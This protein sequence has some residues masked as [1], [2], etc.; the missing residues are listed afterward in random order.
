MSGLLVA[1]GLA[2]AAANVAGRVARDLEASLPIDPVMAELAQRMDDFEDGEYR[3]SAPTV[4][5]LYIH[6]FFSLLALFECLVRLL[7]V[8]LFVLAWGI[9][10]YLS[11]C[12]SCGKTINTPSEPLFIALGARVSVYSAFFCALLANVFCP[13]APTLYFWKR[14]VQL[15]RPPGMSRKR[16]LVTGDQGSCCDCSCDEFGHGMFISNGVSVPTWKMAEVYLSTVSVLHILAFQHNFGLDAW[17]SLCRFH[18]HVEAY[19][20]A[21]SQCAI[22]DMANDTARFYT[23]AYGVDSYEQFLAAR[24]GGGSDGGGRGGGGRG[25]GGGGGSGGGGGVSRQPPSAPDLVRAD[26][27]FPQDHIPVVVAVPLPP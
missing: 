23:K 11:C 25:G 2:A 20:E 4:A 7:F 8:S 27:S 15:I 21:A 10:I 12:L 22:R 24:Y 9:V 5:G 6:W 19:L 16:P 3:R 1:L 26:A 18:L 14:R 13:F 17:P